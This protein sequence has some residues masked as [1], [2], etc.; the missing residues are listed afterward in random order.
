MIS[1][2]STGFCRA[3][4]PFTTA[5]TSPDVTYTLAAAVVA[6]DSTTPLVASFMTSTVAVTVNVLPA[7]SVKALN[8]NLDGATLADTNLRF[9]FVGSTTFHV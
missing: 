1:T 7:V 8:V 5:T 6:D 3:R 4:P 2:R 9:E